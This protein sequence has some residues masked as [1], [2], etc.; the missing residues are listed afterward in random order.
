MSKELLPNETVI[1]NDLAGQ[2]LDKIKHLKYITSQ[3]PLLAQM[4]YEDLGFRHYNQLF[5]MMIESS[6]S[7]EKVRISQ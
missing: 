6:D 5:L 3:N 2:V 7:I 1:L 4:C